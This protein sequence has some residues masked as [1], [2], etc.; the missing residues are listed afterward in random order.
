MRTGGG[1]FLTPQYRCSR[2]PPGTCIGCNPR[3]SC[4]RLLGTHKRLKELC[5]WCHHNQTGLSRTRIV[6]QLAATR[7]AATFSAVRQ[8]SL[9]FPQTLDGSAVYAHDRRSTSAAS[10]QPDFLFPSVLWTNVICEES[11]TVP[12]TTIAEERSESLH[13]SRD[14]RVAVKFMIKVEDSFLNQ[15]DTGEVTDT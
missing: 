7:R 11:Q 10:N 5:G 1:N 13:S 15:L 8:G 3:D 6:E 9:G 12:L 4:R 2:L 14:R